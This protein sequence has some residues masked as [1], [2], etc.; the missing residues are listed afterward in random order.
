MYLF[1]ICSKIVLKIEEGSD[2]EREKSMCIER[3]LERELKGRA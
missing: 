2:L 3:K 1:I